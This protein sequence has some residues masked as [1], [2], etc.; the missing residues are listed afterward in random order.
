MNVSIYDYRTFLLYIICIINTIANN[1]DIQQISQ[2]NNI[3]H[4]T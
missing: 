3:F 4:S 1:Q 2:C